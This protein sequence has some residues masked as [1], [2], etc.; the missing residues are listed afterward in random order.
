VR[1]IGEAD[2]LL[3]FRAQ[4]AVRRAL[5]RLAEAWRLAPVDDIFHLPL[6]LVRAHAARGEP[7]AAESARRIAAEARAA[8]AE[9]TRC[10]APRAFRDGRAIAAAPAAGQLDFWRGRSAGPGTARGPALPVDDLGRLAAD[11]RGRVII[12]QS[13]TPAALVELAGAAGLVCEQGGVLDHAAALARELGMACVVGCAGAWRALAP[14]DEV[15]VDGDAGLVVR[16]SASRP[17]S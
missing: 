9:Q 8:R 7:I 17:G 1:A 15:L 14:G 11:P 6:P 3:F 12:A 5:L 10:G 2:D 4:R 13:I 16:L